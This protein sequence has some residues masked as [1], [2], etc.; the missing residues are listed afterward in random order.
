MR[1][2]FSFLQAME[3]VSKE[4]EPP[5]SEEFAR[6]IRDMKLGTRLE[7]ALED[8]DV[9]VG[10]SEFSLVVT[11]VLIQHQVG[12]NLAQILDNISGTI[13]ERIR[14]RR[15]VLALTAQGRASG[16]V[17]ALLPVALALIL[18]ILNPSYLA[19]LWEDQIGRVA[20][21]VAIVL[22]IIGFFVIHRIVDIEV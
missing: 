7:K 11:A 2:G 5:I 19:P 9:R 1:A 10:C 8:M 14:M 18:S 16:W 12:G 22:E 3:L 6:T 15:E 4:M 13:N 17:L 21:G 20:I